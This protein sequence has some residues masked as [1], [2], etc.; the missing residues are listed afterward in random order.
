VKNSEKGMKRIVV[1]WVIGLIMSKLASVPVAKAGLTSVIGGTTAPAANLGS[2]T[3]VPFTD[4]LRPNYNDC[5]YVMSPFGDNVT[6]NESLK[7]FEIL[8]GWANWS[9]GYKGDVY[10]T[11]E[12]KH[13]VNLTLP[14][15]TSAFYLYA[16][17]N[18]MV[19]HTITAAAC[20]TFNNIVQM[21]QDINGNSGASYF[22]FYCSDG[23]FLKTITI[24]CQTNDFAVG[25]FGI[26]MIPVPEAFFLG[27]IGIC[28]VM[29]LRKQRII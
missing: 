7:H 2:Y 17:P 5:S 25:E 14:S 19:V 16:Q 9:H 27:N 29:K 24:Y 11:G 12:N 15:G 21:N 20:D 8:H 26:S 1:I 18:N 3:M 22:G 4:D 10:W 23:S 6:F 28:I 13:Y